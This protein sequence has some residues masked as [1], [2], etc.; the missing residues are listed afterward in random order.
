M[1]LVER[2]ESFRTDGSRR[3]R[4]GFLVLSIVHESGVSGGSVPRALVAFEERGAVEVV[5]QHVGAVVVE[6]GDMRDASVAVQP[7]AAS[8]ERPTCA[9]QRYTVR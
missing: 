5:R 2:A 3:C 1:S 7:L 8:A 6:V 4:S 9:F